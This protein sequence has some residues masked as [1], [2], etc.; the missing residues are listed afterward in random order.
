MLT[1]DRS[2]RATV[3]APPERCLERLSDVAS[4]PSWSTAPG[5]TKWTDPIT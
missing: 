5:G 1:I 2:A 4:Y 3:G